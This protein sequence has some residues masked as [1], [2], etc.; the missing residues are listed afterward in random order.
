M[1][2]LYKI[3]LNPPIWVIIGTISAAVLLGAAVGIGLYRTL[4]E[5]VSI[6]LLVPAPRPAPDP[7][8]DR[9]AGA[10]A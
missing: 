4:A 1:Q 10:R 7:A 6:H 3:H 5:P 8:H 9:Y 2:N